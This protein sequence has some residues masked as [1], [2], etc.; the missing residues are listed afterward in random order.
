MKTVTVWYDG[1][2]P[3]CTR[4]IALMR[5]L[6]RRAAITFVDVSGAVGECPVERR[7]LLTRFHAEEHGRLVSG[8]EAFAAI[9]RAIPVLRPLGCESAHS[10]TPDKRRSGTPALERIFKRLHELEG[11]RYGSR[12]GAYLGS[13]CAPIHRSSSGTDTNGLTT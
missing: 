8:A 1:D 10:G 2:C 13:R 9:W 4:E 3:L 7:E 6:D 11:R 12:L 5:R